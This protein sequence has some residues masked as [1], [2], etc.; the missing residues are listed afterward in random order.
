MHIREGGITQ[1]YGEGFA[2]YSPLYTCILGLGNF[3]FPDLS[4]GYVVK[5]SISLF[6]FIAAYFA[7][8]ILTLHYGRGSR[9]ALLGAAGVYAL[10]CVMI[11]SFGI[12]QGDMAYCSFL[13]GTLYA[14]M[15]G[16]PVRAMVYFAIAFSLAL[17][18]L[19]L[20]PFLLIL[21]LAKQLPG[22]LAWI[23]A[24]G[25]FV[26]G[27]AAWL[28][29]LPA[30]HYDQVYG[31]ALSLAVALVFGLFT[32]RRAKLPLNAYTMQLLA[33]CS[34]A[35]MPLFL[36]HMIERYFIPAEIFTFVLA[37][38][39]PKVALAALLFQVAHVVSQLPWPGLDGDMRCLIAA[40]LNMLVLS[41]LLVRY[42]RDVF[43]RAGEQLAFL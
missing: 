38:M 14:L 16:K 27:I 1:A 4:P 41:M 7:F 31:L 13:L 29:G 17:Q 39:N 5:T 10:P 8:G 33:T 25:Y 12:G 18:S 11:N 9:M 2:H 30:Y 28:E 43:P 36:P 35:I 34:L 23:A 3:L 21:V 20:G 42:R 15:R 26:V 32:L 19:F 40:L 37:C 6:D 22:R 24:A